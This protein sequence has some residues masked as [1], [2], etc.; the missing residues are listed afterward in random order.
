MVTGACGTVGSE[1]ISQLLSNE[2]CPS[3]IIGID[4][5]ETSLFFLDHK[6]SNDSRIEFFVLDIRDKNDLLNVTKNVDIIFHAAALKHVGLCE[7]SPNQAVNTNILGIQNIIDAA[8]TNSVEKVIF[9]SSDKA[10]NPTNVMGTSKL[11]GERIITAANS[12]KKNQTIFASTRFGNILGSNG[13]VVPVFHNQIVKGLPVTLTSSKMTRFVMNVQQAVKLVIDSAFLAK[14]GEVFVTKMPVIRIEDLAKAM[15]EI[16]SKRY[17]TNISIVEIGSKPGEK[18]Y[19]ELLSEE[20]INRTLE[21]E[22]YY[23]VLPAYRDIYKNIDFKYENTLSNSVEKKYISSEESPLTIQEIK[24]FLI[25]SNLLVKPSNDFTK[26]SWPGD[27][28]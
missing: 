20:E 3:R 28:D 1:L 4:N 21:N 11:M 6:F 24:D 8:N 23:I 5:N 14:G 27:S 19:E 12:Y 15:I 13:S 10:V 25:N 18:L 16:L 22:S 2:Y 17:E 9:T 26:R 7:K